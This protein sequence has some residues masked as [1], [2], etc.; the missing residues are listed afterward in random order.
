MLLTL[1][2]LQQKDQAMFCFMSYVHRHICTIS[3]ELI[4][5]MMVY[6]EEKFQSGFK[7]D[8]S[9]CFLRKDY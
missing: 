8:L 4:Y 3:Y 6:Y 2:T 5:R 7:Y 1:S 9:A